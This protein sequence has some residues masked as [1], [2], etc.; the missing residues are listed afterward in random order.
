M[1]GKADTQTWTDGRDDLSRADTNID[2]KEALMDRLTFSALCTYTQSRHL[3]TYTCVNTPIKN[4]CPTM[5]Q[6]GATM[7]ANVKM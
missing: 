3:Y 7:E 2:Q 4:K 6:S 5:E 1:W